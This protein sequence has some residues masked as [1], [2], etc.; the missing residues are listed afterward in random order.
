MESTVRQLERYVAAQFGDKARLISL[1]GM[2]SLEDQ[3]MKG[4]GYGKPLLLQIEV[5]GRMVEAVLSTMRGDAYGHQEYW[6]RAAILMFQHDAAGR[7][8]KHAKPIALGYFDQKGDLHP[9]REP[10]EFFLIS[11]KV[12]GYD[13]FHDLERIRKGDLR[14]TDLEMARNFSRW[15]AR[16]HSQKKDAPDLYQRRIRD[17]IGSSE[18]IMGLI[19]NAYPHPYSGYAEER[20]LALEQELIR[21]RY[22]LNKHTDRLAA[23]HGDFHP[24]NVLVTG[25][26]DFTV[27][28]RSRGEWGEPADD[29]AT[30]G[31]NYLLFGLYDKPELSGPFE[32]VFMAYF[33]EYLEATGDSRILEFMAP[34]FVFRALVIAS[35]QWYPNHPDSVRQGLF[36]FMENV[37]ADTRFDYRNVNKYME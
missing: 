10:R 12:E 5:D 35:P 2:S 25:D 15:M 22:L 20:F 36:R 14:E 31:L 28:D 6:D 1:G 34:F 33:D 16:L 37:L 27:L 30:M 13:Y 4:F 3:G 18:C 29:L 19:D 9:V 8:E 17:L 32:K 7:M 26:G 21:W 24:W 23:V 11:E